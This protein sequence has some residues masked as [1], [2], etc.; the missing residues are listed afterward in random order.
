[1]RIL[2]YMSTYGGSPII[3]NDFVL[4]LSRGFF[5]TLAKD[6]IIVMFT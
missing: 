3:R 2:S 6:A 4:Q 5:Y 1:M